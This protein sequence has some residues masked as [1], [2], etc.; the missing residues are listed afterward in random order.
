MDPDPKRSD[1]T[2]KEVVWMAPDVFLRSFGIV[3][4]HRVEVRDSDVTTMTTAPDKVLEVDGQYLVNVETQ[5]RYNAELERTLWYRQVA[6]DYRH[7]LPALTL[8]IL[9]RKEANAK[10]LKGS[11]RRTLPDGT[12]VSQ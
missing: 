11:L 12:V 3:P 2:A 5:C 1:V 8:L 9:F 10:A 7:G 6:L 4:R